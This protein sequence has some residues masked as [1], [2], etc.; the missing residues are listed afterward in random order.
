[1]ERKKDIKPFF[2]AIGPE[3]T[4]TSWLYENLKEHPEIK[5]NSIKEIRYLWEN[6]YVGNV[7]L[8]NKVFGKHWHLYSNRNKLKN[9][10]K[11]F[12]YFLLKRRQLKWKELR[13]HLRFFFFKHNE[14][15]YR[16]L[17]DRTKVTGDITPKYCELNEKHVKLFHDTVPEAKIIISLRDPIERQWSWM[18]MSLLKHRGLEH[19]N[20]IDKSKIEACVKDNA[21]IQ[22]NDYKSLIDRWSSIFG[23]ENVL[24]LFFDE[25]HANPTQ[26]L[27][28]VEQFLNLEAHTYEGISKFSN[29]GLDIEIPSEIEEKLMKLNRENIF[30]MQGYLNPEQVNRWLQRYE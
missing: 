24:V 27:S 12:L 7:N 11:S 28:R 30:K 8:V 20:Q 15:W 21:M 9:G 2:I 5:M 4:G 14:K 10:A 17:F 1:M 3:K 25:L 19:L 18:K 16:S 29:K 26:F 23:K 6:Q 13:W 22:S